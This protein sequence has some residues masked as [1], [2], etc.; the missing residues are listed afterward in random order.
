MVY[1]RKLFL[2][3]SALVLPALV[4]PGPYAGTM[5]LIG[6]GGA[7]PGIELHLPPPLPPAPAAPASG[8]WVRPYTQGDGGVGAVGGYSSTGGTSVTGNVYVPHYGPP[9]GGASVETHF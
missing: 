4:S 1:F 2:A 5:S 8:T 9:A 3:A 7:G 6:G